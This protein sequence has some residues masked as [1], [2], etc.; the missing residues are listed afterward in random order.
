MLLQEK[1]RQ[2]GPKNRICIILVFLCLNRSSVT[3]VILPS[4]KT[5]Q[6]GETHPLPKDMD[7][8]MSDQNAASDEFKKVL[9]DLHKKSGKF[10]V[11][12][13]LG[14]IRDFFEGH[15]PSDER[16]RVLENAYSIATVGMDSSMFEDTEIIILAI[17]AVTC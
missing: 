16:S 3:L 8:A 10:L 14:L 9:H 4:N 11:A 7:K 2:K 12:D 1:K 15:N 17:R 6:K 5:L 13:L